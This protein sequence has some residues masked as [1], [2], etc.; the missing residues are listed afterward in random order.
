M[1]PDILG[2]QEVTSQQYRYLKEN[3]AGY[4][5]IIEYRDSMPWSEGCPIFL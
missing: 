5:G 2:F 4:S 1:M 3:M